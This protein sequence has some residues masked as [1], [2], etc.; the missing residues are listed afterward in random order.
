MLG[1]K[2]GGEH[3]VK[4]GGCWPNVMLTLSPKLAF[5]SYP[6]FQLSSQRSGQLRPLQAH[7]SI[8]NLSAVSHHFARKALKAQPVGGVEAWTSCR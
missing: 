4:L 8:Y 3:K 5:S 7:P 2:R 1:R 6:D